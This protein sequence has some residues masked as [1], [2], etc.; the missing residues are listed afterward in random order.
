MTTW[1]MDTALFKTLGS[2]RTRQ[3]FEDNDAS[4]FLSAASL[5]EI[6]ATIAKIPMGQRQRALAL[7]AWFDELASRYADRIHPVEPEI[8]VRAG[9][10]MPSVHNG[11]HR[12]RLHDALLV[13]TAQIH[14][15]GLLTRR[16]GIFGPWIKVP[17]A[18]V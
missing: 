3:W 7:R 9:E 4:V 16:E 10:L 14:G 11:H 18:T 15:H 8:A 2:P 6:V 1:L 5:S 13:A 12:H 17:I